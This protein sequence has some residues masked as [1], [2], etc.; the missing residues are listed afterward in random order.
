MTYCKKAI[1]T[2]EYYIST[3]VNRVLRKEGYYVRKSI[4]AKQD[5]KDKLKEF[6][7]LIG[8]SGEEQDIIRA[9]IKHMEPY[10]DEIKV[11]TLGNLTAVKKGNRPGPTVLIASH[12]D[13]IGFSVKYISDEMTASFTS[14]K[15][16]VFLI[17]F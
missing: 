7:S 10:A 16:A 2:C 3:S 13:E 14:I 5:L 9:M 11:S 12:S 15:L 8:V 4:S 1:E 6:T 17:M